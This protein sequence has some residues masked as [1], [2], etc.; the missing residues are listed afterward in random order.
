VQNQNLWKAVYRH[1]FGETRLFFAAWASVAI[2]VHHFSLNE[3]LHQ[4]FHWSVPC[5]LYGWSFYLHWEILE[6][7][8]G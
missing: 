7:V 4:R 3:V 8:E 1:V 6:G 5:H 2:A